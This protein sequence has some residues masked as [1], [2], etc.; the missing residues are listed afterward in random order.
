GPRSGVGLKYLEVIPGRARRTFRQGDTI[1]L[2]GRPP[3]VEYEDLFSTFDKPTRDNS[4]TALKGFGDAFA[5][6][7]ES[8]NQAI[9]AFNPFFRHLTPV[10]KTLD[11]PDTRL[12]DFFRN[13]GHA[14]AEVAPVASAR[15]D[16][17]TR[18]AR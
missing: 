6:R 10:M 1:P 3:A 13:L 15:A 16:A 7:G 5:G 18:L 11:A 8:I 9:A 12:G 17:C 2:S 14:A 4:R